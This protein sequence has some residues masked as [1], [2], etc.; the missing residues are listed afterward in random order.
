MFDAV[1]GAAFGVVRRARDDVGS[2][3]YVGTSRDGSVGAIRLRGD[4]TKT[5]EAT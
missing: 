3:G 2:S 1:L 4:T 5:R